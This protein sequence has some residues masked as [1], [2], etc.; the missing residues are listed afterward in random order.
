[1]S[2]QKIKKYLEP[3]RGKPPNFLSLFD[4]VT[5]SCKYQYNEQTGSKIVGARLVLAP[6]AISDDMSV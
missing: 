5:A 1:M 2:S 6:M 3:I 4:H